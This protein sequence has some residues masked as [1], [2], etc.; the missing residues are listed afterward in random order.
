MKYSYFNAALIVLFILFVSALS[1]FSHEGF[2]KSESSSISFPFLSEKPITEDGYYALTVA[3]NIGSGKGITYNYSGE[4]TGF[5]PLYVFLLSVIAKA[6][7]IFGWGKIEFVRAVLLFSGLL[8]LIFLLVIRNISKFLL[9]AYDN[10]YVGL[11]S[12]LLVLFNYKVFLNFF[13]GLETGLYLIFIS[14]TIFYS[15]RIISNDLKLG[16]LFYLGLLLGLTT[17]ARI[18]FV[19]PAF[20]FLVYLVYKRKMK[21][22]QF[23]YVIFI[24]SLLLIPWLI[25][26]FSV[27]HSFIPTSV[28][29]QSAVPSFY[30][31][32]YRVDQLVHSVL[33]PF[34]PFYFTGLK[35]TILFY[36]PSIFILLVLYKIFLAEK[37]I[38]KLEQIR[39]FYIWGL[40]FIPLIIVYGIYSSVP[41]FFFRYLSFLLVF[42]LPIL[43]TMLGDYFVNHRKELVPSIILL[44]IILFSVNCYVGLFSARKGSSLAVRADF[45]I[46]NIP[47]GQ[48][49]GIFQSGIAGFYSEDVVNLD[50]KMNFKALEYAKKGVL[51][52]YIDSLKIDI[53]LEWKEGFVLLR[54]SYLENN[55]SKFPETVPDNRSII[56]LRKKQLNNI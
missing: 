19:L 32:H 20:L 31:F 55:W 15:I 43:I 54:K 7:N 5:Q 39:I 35:S 27:T 22:I 13:N 40:S 46:K 48:K 21:L 2:P 9:A 12:T 44:A 45:L 25:Y 51:D 10:K 50:G 56:Y 8:L 42:T 53:L 29:V 24:Y 3:W 41:Y 49:I 28:L 26:V 6:L 38:Y 33:N 14:L 34:V 16:N 30:E 18:D 47:T 11:L 17:L 52:K 1:F 23:A 4:T 37:H 36:I